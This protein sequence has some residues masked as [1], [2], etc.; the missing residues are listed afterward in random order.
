MFPEA[1]RYYLFKV[2][3][4]F[5][6]L[7]LV[8]VGCE[9][10]LANQSQTLEIT[11]NKAVFAL[12]ADLEGDLP[13]PVTEARIDIAE[14]LAKKSGVNQ[15]TLVGGN[16]GR[17]GSA[18][19]LLNRQRAVV[20]S[21]RCAS[22]SYSTRSNLMEIKASNYLD[23]SPAFV[24]VTS[25]IHSYRVRYLCYQLEM[26]CLVEEVETT[27]PRR[28][29]LQAW[30]HEAVAMIAEVLLGSYADKIIAHIRLSAARQHHPQTA[31]GPKFALWWCSQCL[32]EDTEG[33]ATR[34]WG[35]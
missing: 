20:D 21:L 30:I 33:G 5:F 31:K 22:R 27:S 32:R 19:A 34:G 9:L 26:Q 7:R 25:E 11:D 2:P 1:L 23:V 4:S 28:A 12:L 35:V 10:T 8:Y 16:R 14:A 15:V 17:H 13:G 6:I 18:C 3:L 24:L 29:I